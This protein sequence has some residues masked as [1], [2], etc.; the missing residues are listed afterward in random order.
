MAPF[1]L[2]N[3]GAGALRVRL[4][5]YVLGTALGLLPG[6][7]LISLFMRQVQRAVQ[8]ATPGAWLALAAGALL[9]LGAVWWLQRQWRRRP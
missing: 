5:D 2:V 6:T 3:L 8:T 1:I 9:V 7:V 4:R